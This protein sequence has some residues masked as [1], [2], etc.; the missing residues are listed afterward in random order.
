MSSDR[1]LKANKA[2]I[3]RLTRQQRRE[4]CVMDAKDVGKIMGI[5]QQMV[6]VIEIQAL[7]KIKR[8]LAEYYK[9]LC[10]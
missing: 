2:H 7:T 1:Y 10:E 3:V 4:L 8:I 5:S 6:S 9:H